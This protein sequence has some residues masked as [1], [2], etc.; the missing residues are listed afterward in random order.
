MLFTQKAFTE[1][2]RAL[3]YFLSMQMDKERYSDDSK[4]Q[5][6]AEQLLSLLTPI[7]K[8]FLSEVCLEATS[9][10][11]Q[12]FGG[13]GYIK[14]WGQERHFRDARITSIYEGT[15]GIQGLDL[16][17]RKILASQGKMLQGFIGI[18]LNFCQQNPSSPYAATLQQQM[19]HWGK[20]TAE[21]GEKAMRNPDEVNAAAYDY[22]LFSG[23]SVFAW[24]WA[25]SAATAQAALEQ[26]PSAHDKKFYEGKLATA[27]FFFARLLPRTQA[28]AIS[29]RAGV[30]TLPE[31]E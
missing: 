31:M 13:H 6:E 5:A 12:V 11:I 18:V 19:Q 28:L 10:G 8:G 29:I 26:N 14:E 21:I 24:I 1:G 16:L 3:S 2:G 17:G 22:L 30:S 15:S 4:V 23:Y 7:A 9:Y 27:E 25:Q 20:L